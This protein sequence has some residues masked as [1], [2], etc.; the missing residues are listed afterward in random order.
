MQT[1]TPVFQ[2]FL[3]PSPR[4]MML[5]VFML[6]VFIALLLTIPWRWELSIIAGIVGLPY[7]LME[8][9]RKVLLAH[10]K[11]FICLGADQ[12]GWWLQRRNGEKIYGQLS[13]GCVLWQHWVT[14][15]IKPPGLRLPVAVG[16]MADGLESRDDFR[17]L[18]QYLYLSAGQKS[19]SKPEGLASFNR[20]RD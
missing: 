5:Y 14:V 11:S 16:V 2:F 17:K 4:M 10:N 12:H 19:P 7:W 20:S 6:S 3:Q 18:K 15:E 8:F 13:P 1:N 9:Q